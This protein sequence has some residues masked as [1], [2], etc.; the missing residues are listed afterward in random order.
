M[1]ITFLGTGAAD[2]DYNRDRNIDG[3]R[4]NSSALIDDIF[5]IDP[6]PNV[7][8]ALETFGKNANDIKYII[9]THRHPD[10][11]NEYTVKALT[12]AKFYDLKEGTETSIGKY[13]VKALKA[14]HSTCK[15]AVHFIIS[16]GKKNIFYGLDGAWLMYDEVSAIQN[17][18]IDFA[19]FDATV[20]DI[21]GDYRIFEHNNLGM[22]LEMKK[23]LEK[24]IKRFCISHMAKTLHKPHKE[25]AEDMKKHNVETAFDDYE[26][27]I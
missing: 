4:R 21:Y 5:L 17:T 26:T 13:N 1:K 8:E 6:G 7:I 23:S 10:H 25:L 18:N 24:Y 14:N 15:E 16:D 11:Y 2:W 27:E 3:F 22:V 12:S 9:N 20:G 19:V